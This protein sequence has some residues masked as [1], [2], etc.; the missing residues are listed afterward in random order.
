MS[1]SAVPPTTRIGHVHLRVADLGRATIFYRDVLGLGVV[2]GIDG[3]AFL[4]AGDYHHHVALNTWQT[5][6]GDAPPPGHTGLHHFAILLPDRAAL[7][8]VVERLFA[9]G[10]PI[11]AAEDHGA[12]VA[13][14]L[15]DPDGN[16][17]ELSYD[18]P[19]VAW[20]DGEGRPILKADSFDPLELVHGW[21]V[22][23]PWQPARPERSACSS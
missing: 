3:A 2:A 19:R 5:E 18:R 9:A 14:Y 12:T 17:I 4:A 13:V 16:G 15:R 7:A 23:V 21:C 10:Y 22:P 1:T 20:F 11:D 8:A 6:G